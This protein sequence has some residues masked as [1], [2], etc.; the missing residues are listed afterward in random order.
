MSLAIAALLGNSV[1]CKKC[2]VLW[3]VKMSRTMLALTTLWLVL[4][5]SASFYAALFL[6]NFW[7]LLVS[8]GVL[9]MLFFY[10]AQRA[11]LSKSFDL[12]RR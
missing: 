3:R 2:G 9:A 5:C 12:D 8:W 11:T 6:F 10:G 7:P 1:K 4:V